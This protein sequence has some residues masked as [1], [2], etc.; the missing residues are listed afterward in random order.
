MDYKTVLISNFPLPYSD[1]GSWTKL[2]DNYLRHENL[3]DYIVCPKVDNKFENV[4]YSF[5]KLKITD[6]LY[7]RIYSKYR[8]NSYFRALNK[9]IKFESNDL[10]IQIIDNVNLVFS[11]H[12]YYRKKNLRNRFYIQFFYHGFPPF[13]NENRA[14]VFFNIVD[15]IILLT[16]DSYKSFLKKYNQLP[17]K[18]SVLHNGID[19]NIFFSIL[20]KEKKQKRKL[21]KSENKIVFVW[22]SQDRKKKGLFILLEAW[23]RVYNN[24]KNIELWIIGTDK[25]TEKLD[26][27]G[28]IFFGKM[29]NDDI[30]SVIQLSDCY[31]FPVLNQEG[32]GLSLIEA[33]HCGNYVISS[34]LGGIPEVL[35]YGKFGKL[36]DYPNIVET[37][38]DAINDY[39]QNP[40][41]NNN[42]DYTLYTSKEWNSNMNKIINS[43]RFK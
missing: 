33:L 34:N 13:L 37:W 19:T 9:I 27:D 23:K 40:I 30:P 18:I 12:E 17:I 6:K 36:I 29:S 38:E 10:I 5:V 21:L 39:I 14:Y 28:I 42:F 15:E 35:Q 24:N 3:I 11:L 2:Y 16:F 4:K 43:V 32:F 7:S 41:F 1:T 25:K 22:M 31:L 8:F 20:H 26:E